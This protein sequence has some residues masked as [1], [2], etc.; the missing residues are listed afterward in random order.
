MRFIHFVLLLIFIF[1]CSKPVPQFSQDNAFTYIEKQIS[2]GPRNPGSQG[3]QACFDFLKTE[4]E[5]SASVVRVQEFN[6]YDKRFDQNYRLKNIVAS[7]YPS[8]MNRVLLAAHWDT[9]PIA[10]KETD[11]LKRNQ[12][13]LGANDGAA[14]VA[15]L[16]EIATVLKQNEPAFGI[17]IVLFDGE[18]LGSK[19]AGDNYS[20]GS[21][22]FA[23]VMTKYKP[24]FGI[25]I[26]LIGGKDL[27]IRKEFFS[28]QAYPNVIRKVWDHAHDLGYENVFMEEI[29]ES[30]MDD[31][32]PLI[33]IGIPIINIIDME[34]VNNKHRIHHTQND[35]ID[36][37]DKQS[38]QIIGDV[39]LT[40]IYKE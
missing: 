2:F 31:H 27:L 33:K 7:F 6:W 1:S 24:Q 14:A 16:L 23:K 10:E 20:I 38:L 15:V 18:D 13:I 8:K 28:N 32:V 12:P 3:H 9:N 25:L 40:S 34:I 30:I 22:E 11:S 29:G 17:D 39:L 37:I 4:L 36:Q 21:K 19:D 35:V 26:D 5:K